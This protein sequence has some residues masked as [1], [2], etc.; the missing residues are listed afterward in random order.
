MDE[1]TKHNY[2]APARDFTSRHIRSPTFGHVHPATIQVSLRTR[3]V[4]SETF[5]RA[6]RIAKGEKFL[7]AENE[8]FDQTARMRRLI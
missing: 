7:H 3:T 1:Q 6:F 2:L 8:D 5:L 4:W